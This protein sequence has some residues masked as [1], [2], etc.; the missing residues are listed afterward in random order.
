MKKI[1]LL[2]LIC[3]FVFPFIRVDAATT[4]KVLT[5]EGTTSGT[6][7]SYN[8]TTEEGSTAVMCKL[9]NTDSEELEMLS[10]P[11]D[12]KEFTGTFTVDEKKDYIVACANYEGGEIKKITVSFNKE[13][14]SNNTNDKETSKKITNSNNVKTSDN[15]I[16]FVI[17]SFISLMATIS[18]LIIKKKRA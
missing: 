17:L 5:L 2:V 4:P 10:S 11:V 14:T 18:L 3:L 15:I 8:G 13:T 6:S 16:K 7:I 12:N 1:K 9:L